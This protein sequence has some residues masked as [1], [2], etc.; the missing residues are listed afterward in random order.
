VG[1]P[2]SL[3]SQHKQDDSGFKDVAL[4]SSKGAAERGGVGEGGYS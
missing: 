1:Q 3:D 4:K 2:N